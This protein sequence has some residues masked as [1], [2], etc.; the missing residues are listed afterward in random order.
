MIEIIAIFIVY[1]I[2]QAILLAVGVGIGLLLHWC[3]PSLTTDM[4][5]LVG[6]LSAITSAYFI[7]LMMRAK[8]VDIIEEFLA[9]RDDYDVEDEE[10]PELTIA[11]PSQGKRQGRKSK[12]S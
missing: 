1:L 8:Y 2:L 4:A 11:V 3:V 6:V 5:V 7:G 12:R 9:E 10:P